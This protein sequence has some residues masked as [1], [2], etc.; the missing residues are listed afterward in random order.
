MKKYLSVARWEYLEKVRTKSFL[1]GL[2]FTPFAILLFNTLPALLIEREEENTINY[3]IIDS[4]SEIYT[5]LN[6]TLNLKF[7]KKDK[8]K[9]YNLQFEKINQIDTILQKTI[10]NKRIL[11]NDIDGYFIFNLNDN[12]KIDYF[13]DKIGFGKDQ[14]RIENIINEIIFAKRIRQ[15]GLQ[16]EKIQ[17]LKPEIILTSFKINEE[18]ESSKADFLTTFFTS[19]VFIILFMILTLQTGQML[20]RSVVEEK[21]NRLIEVLLSSCSS[22]DLLIGKILGLALLGL[23]TVVVW[24]LL[25]VIILLYSATV[26]FS[27][28]IISVLLILIYFSIG[29]LFI[30]SIFVTFGS[31]ITTEQEAQQITGY[32]SIMTALPVAF[33]FAMI[34][35]PD[36]EIAKILSFIP[37]FT[38]TFMILRISLKMPEVW[39]IIV[40]LVILIASTYGMMIVGSKIFKIGIL[41]T[42]KKP[43]LKELIKWLKLKD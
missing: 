33:L 20:V 1:F 38:P 22:T 16:F 34:Q 30:S 8:S 32:I 23:T 7:R 15:S 11:E 26:T 39:E 28:S 24:L 17:S 41:V 37:I 18:G 12:L 40:S 9:L 42:G 25:G 2:F 10:L 21:S 14:I 4:D 6:D 13:S 29:Y 27:L 36:S 31:A 43:N 19:Y 35:N 3:V 5:Q